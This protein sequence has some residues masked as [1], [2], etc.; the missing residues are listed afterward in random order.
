MPAMFANFA[1]AQ[2]QIVVVAQVQQFVHTACLIIKINK[3]I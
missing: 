3:I 2:S 1:V